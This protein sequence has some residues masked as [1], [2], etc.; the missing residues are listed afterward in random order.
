MR[1]NECRGIQNLGVHIGILNNTQI[2]VGREVKNPTHAW[3]VM[4]FY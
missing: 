2:N 3:N 1:L 4:E